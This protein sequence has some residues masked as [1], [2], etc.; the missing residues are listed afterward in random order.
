MS[1]LRDPVVEYITERFAKEDFILNNLLAE[2]EAGGGPMMNI[3]PDQ[4]KFL[5]LLVKL[6]RPKN[7]LEVGS[8]YGYSSI[9]L[10]RAVHELNRSSDAEP[11]QAQS[12]HK[13]PA[14]G[15]DQGICE[16]AT[17][18]YL[19]VNEDG[20][21]TNNAEPSQAQSFHKTPALGLDQGI[22]EGVTGVY[23]NVNEDGERTN[24]AEPSQ[25]QSLHKTPALGLD[26]GI[27]EGATG[28]YLNVNEDGERTN[29]AELSQVRKSCLTCVEVSQ[30]H[31]D[32]IRDHLRQ[33]G[34]EQ[35]AEVFNGAGLD[36]MQKFIREGRQFEMIFIDADK[37]NY[38]NYVDLAVRLLPAGGLL[39]VD[40]ALW[41]GEVLKE[42]SSVDAS[43]RAIQEFNDKLAKSLDFDSV[44]V[45]IQDGIAFAIKR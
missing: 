24:N 9:W 28:V 43:T 17:G 5:N 33:A 13:T 20:E 6:L 11:S 38:S 14:L 34:L 35:D 36:L 41:K 45:T 39:L 19:N 37:A 1:D 16:R 23:L 22:C 8:Y 31:A 42:P 27:C 29:N 12:L 7:I 3:G 26:Q 15:L 32:I 21:R 10:A 25:A 18:V 4:G 40:N 2:Q 30:L 44:I